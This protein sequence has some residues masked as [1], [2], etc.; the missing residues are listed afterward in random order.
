M[1][2]VIAEMKDCQARGKKILREEERKR[3]GGMQ[4][5]VV[6]LGVIFIIWFLFSQ[7]EGKT[8]IR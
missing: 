5:V 6:E 3:E 7:V 2:C 1:C 8:P 4:Y